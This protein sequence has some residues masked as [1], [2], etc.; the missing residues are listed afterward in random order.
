MLL[1]TL[2]APHPMKKHFCI[3]ITLLLSSLFFSQDLKAAVYQSSWLSLTIDNCTGI[4][5]IDFVLYVD[6]DNDNNDDGWVDGAKLRLKIGNGDYFNLGE[7]GFT[8]TDQAGA[9]IFHD[10]NGDDFYYLNEGP[11]QVGSQTIT[12]EGSVENMDADRPRWIRVRFNLNEG[13]QG[14]DISVRIDGTWEGGLGPSVKT[15]QLDRT[16][17]F[18]ELQAT[19]QT[20]CGGVNLEWSTPSGMCAGTTID[21][22]RDDVLVHTSQASDGSYFDSEAVD[23]VSHQYRAIFLKYMNGYWNNYGGYSSTKPGPTR[24]SPIFLPGLQPPMKI[25]TTAWT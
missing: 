10:G 21:I 9:I 18:T 1:N 13:S 5:T 22:Y 8:E 25:A 11:S 7:L 12:D 19:N 20:R 14:Q 17:D 3:G 2:N 15:A 23:Y 16:A 4:A 24:P 6:V